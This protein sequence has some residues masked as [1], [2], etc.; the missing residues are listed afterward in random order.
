MTLT[1]FLLL[2]SKPKHCRS[3]SSTAPVK[4][5]WGPFRLAVLI[6]WKS[7]CFNPTSPGPT[8]K[9]WPNFKDKGHGTGI[10]I[11]LPA[12]N[13]LKHPNRSSIIMYSPLLPSDQRKDITCVYV[14]KVVLEES[15]ICYHRPLRYVLEKQSYQF[16]FHC[17]GFYVISSVHESCFLP[18]VWTVFQNSFTVVDGFCQT[19]SWCLDGPDELQLFSFLD[20]ASG[21]TAETKSVS[22]ISQ[23]Q[24]V[25]KSPT[26]LDE[27]MDIWPWCTFSSITTWYYV[28]ADQLWR[29]NIKI[30]HCPKE[31]ELCTLILGRIPGVDYFQ[32]H[33][34][35][36][37]CACI[38]STVSF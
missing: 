15:L 8:M 2:L 30:C 20:W 38:V 34:W 14:V 13:N 6:R 29:T 9:L 22:Q 32:P 37:I 1:H 25:D 21:I 11:G 33:G 4:G 35:G 12:R 17:L 10:G 3:P 5:W 23:C 26:V 7:T 18:E 28:P 24:G 16:S 36:K 19:V 31:G 27:K